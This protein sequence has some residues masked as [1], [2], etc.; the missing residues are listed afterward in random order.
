VLFATG[1]AWAQDTVPARIERQALRE[2]L[3]VLSGAGCNVTVWTGADA[4]VVVD[5]GSAASAEQLL[6]ALPR[7]PAGAT[8][9]LIN[10]H[11]HPDHTGA[12]ESLG[13]AGVAVVAHD[14]VRRRMGMPQS[15]PA[16]DLKVP[17]A[18]GVALPVVTF[19][20]TLSLHLNGDRLSLLH[21]PSAHTDG[22]VLAWWEEA[23]VLHLGDLYY[24]D[25]YPFLDLASGGSLAGL[26]AALETALSRAD[27]QT[28]VVPGH[29]PVG[30]RADLTAYRD[31]L[32]AVGRAVR[33]LIE[34]GRSAE[35]V[36]AARPT[37]AYDARFGK[38]SVSAERFVRTLY[39]DLG[40][41]R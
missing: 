36:V 6:E 29:G 25:G 30:R 1:A 35:E 38:G 2:G 22:D 4:L 40:G 3:Q 24:A 15:V 17:A 16:Y 26:I 20:E 39:E 27:A 28:L 18:P 13:R 9:F 7:A 19:D 33:T 8:R 11:W 12:N 41:R 31:M 37:E 21:V 10:T 32:V 14:N 34:Q 23:N 5:A